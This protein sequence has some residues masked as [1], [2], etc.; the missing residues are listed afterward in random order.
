MRHTP[1]NSMPIRAIKTH[2]ATVGNTIQTVNSPMYDHYHYYHIT[3]QNNKG[4]YRRTSPERHNI[5]F[6]LNQHDDVKLLLKN[7]V[8]TKINQTF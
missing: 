3:H 8:N 6:S 7:K 2:T 1:I 5:E 4:I